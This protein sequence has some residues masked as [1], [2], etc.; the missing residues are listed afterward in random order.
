MKAKEMIDL[1][2]HTKY[3]ATN[4]CL[5]EIRKRKMYNPKKIFFN[6]KTPSSAIW[7][8]EV[9]IRAARYYSG[10][11]P[12]FIQMSLSRMNKARDLEYKLKRLNYSQRTKT[13]I[14]TISERIK[15]Y[16]ERIRGFTQ[17]RFERSNYEYIDII[18]RI[19][20]I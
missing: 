7:L 9:L 10:E 1:N 15:K 5:T 12:E 20:H 11:K 13:D 14:D 18:E 2:N 4:Q 17:S 6:K 16:E 3:N 19:V 8:Q